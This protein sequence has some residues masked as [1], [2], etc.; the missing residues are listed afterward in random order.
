MKKILQV[1]AMIVLT[2]GVVYAG[3]VSSH[4]DIRKCNHEWES[5]NDIAKHEKDS[6]QISYLR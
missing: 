2:A 3:V 6:S 5:G 1:A 4:R